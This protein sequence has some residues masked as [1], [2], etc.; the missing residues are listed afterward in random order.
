MHNVIIN[1]FIFNGNKYNNTR[2]SFYQQICNSFLNNRDQDKFKIFLEKGNVNV[3]S[4]F[5]YNIYKERQDVL[6]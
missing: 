5:I 4:R 1:T 6:F 3:F 2:L